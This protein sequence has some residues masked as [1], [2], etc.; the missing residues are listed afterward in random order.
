[1]KNTML[2]RDRGD[3]RTGRLQSPGLGG[4]TQRKIEETR[5]QAAEDVAKAQADVT[6]RE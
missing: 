2:C 3:A 5:Q 6:W 4:G 1:M